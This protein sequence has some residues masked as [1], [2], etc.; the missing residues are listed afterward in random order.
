MQI[1]N[2]LPNTDTVSYYFSRCI[3]HL[4]G[5]LPQVLL[6]FQQRFKKT[7]TQFA[8]SELYDRTFNDNIAISLSILPFSTKQTLMIVSGNKQNMLAVTSYG[9]G[10]KEDTA[11]RKPLD[12]IKI[13]ASTENI[14]NMQQTQAITDRKNIKPFLSENERLNRIFEGTEF[15]FSE[16]LQTWHNNISIQEQIS[17]VC[18]NMIANYVLGIPSLSREQAKIITQANRT[19]RD[20]QPNDLEFIA[21]R[22][23][24]AELNRDLLLQYKDILLAKDNYIHRKANFTEFDSEDTKLKKLLDT[25][26][27]SNL[28]VE[29]NLSA[30]IM[31]AIIAINQSNDVRVKLLDELKMKDSMILSEIRKLTYLDYVYKEALRFASPTPMIVRE[32]SKTMTIHITNDQGENKIY[33]LPP[34]S[35]LFAPIRRMHYDARYFDK[36]QEFN[37]ERFADP[38]AL[39]HFVPYSIGMRSCPAAAHFNEVVFKAAIKAFLKYELTFDK[40]I[41]Q[42]PVDSLTSRFQQNYY[43]TNIVNVQSHSSACL[44]KM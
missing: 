34:H 13:M 28:L 35:L 4:S 44:F 31:T 21:W 23:S 3:D 10:E 6:D 11:A 38:A 19:L 12:N 39:T 24:L 26:G 17:Y 22:D 42:I 15:A 14:I 29:S 9:D 41:E 33:R 1:R 8:V 7:D 30:L 32:T 37:P 2:Y 25:Y 16:L 43:V 27:V 18:I 20:K 36:P 5:Y 40:E